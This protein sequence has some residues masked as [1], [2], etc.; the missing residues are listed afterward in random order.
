MSL[1]KTASCREIFASFDDPGGYCFFG[2]MMLNVHPPYLLWFI[3]HLRR[4]PAGLG[5]LPVG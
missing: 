4:S 1:Q 5:G 2:S 3:Q